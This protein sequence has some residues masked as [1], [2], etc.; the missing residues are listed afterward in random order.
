MRAATPPRVLSTDYSLDLRSV[1][2]VVRERTSALFD[3]S[4]TRSERVVELVVSFFRPRA[5]SLVVVVVLVSSLTP[6]RA[7]GTSTTFFDSSTVRRLDS[8]VA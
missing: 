7:F 4:G 5:P 3:A 8:V 1:S 6:A 2:T